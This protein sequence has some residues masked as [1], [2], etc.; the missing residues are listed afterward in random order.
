MSYGCH[1]NFLYAGTEIHGAA[2]ARNEFSGDGPVGDITFLIHLECAEDR[3]VDMTATDI[4]EGVA[5][6][7][8]TAAGNHGCGMPAGID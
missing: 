3:N 7:G 8:D 1:N 2:H 4:S 6:V 5:V